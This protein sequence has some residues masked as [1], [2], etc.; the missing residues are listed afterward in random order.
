MVD[1]GLQGHQSDL[2]NVEE[3]CQ[4]VDSL[5]GDRSKLGGI[6]AEDSAG[7]AALRSLRIMRFCAAWRA[8]R[9]R[10]QVTLEYFILF[11]VIAVLTVVSLTRVDDQVRAALTDFANAA[12]ARVAR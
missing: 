6:V 10:G 8:L 4:S 1:Q 5:S 11:A 9:S 7:A 12:A 3:S 2:S